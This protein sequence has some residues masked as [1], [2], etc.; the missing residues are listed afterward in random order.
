MWNNNFLLK[1]HIYLLYK[2]YI[3]IT[4]KASLNLYLSLSHKMP[5]SRPK[6]LVI[7]LEKGRRRT[8][9]YLHKQYNKTRTYILHV[10][11]FMYET[12]YIV[13]NIWVLSMYIVYYILLYE[14]F[15]C[16]Y[17]V[18]YMSYLVISMYIV[19]YIPT[20]GLFLSR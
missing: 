2:P 12:Y 6:Y 16:T 15:L 11:L 8:R 10:Q 19:Y 14:L 5:N 20:Y 1:L 4:I 3:C 7:K 18:Y 9:K 13:A 17:I